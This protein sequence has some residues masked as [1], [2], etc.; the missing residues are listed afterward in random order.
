MTTKPW[1]PGGGH[2]C[3]LT[4]RAPGECSREVIGCPSSWAWLDW[5]EQAQLHGPAQPGSTAEGLF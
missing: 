2:D 5:A 1:L 4:A 3:R